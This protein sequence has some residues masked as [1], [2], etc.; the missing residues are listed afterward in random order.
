[1][2]TMRH[3]AGARVAAIGIAAS[4]ALLLVGCGAANEGGPSSGGGGSA[5][6]MVS[7]TISG[8]GAST[9]QAA[10]QAWVAGFTAIN[11]DAVINYDPTGSGAGRTQFMVG[12]VDWA[13]SDAYLEGDELG[14]ANQRCGSG[15]IVEGPVYISPIAVVYNLPGVPN[16]QLSPAT[17]AKIFDR[18][19]TKW[20]DPAVAADN[21]R[22][23]LPAMPI[24][25]VNRSD[26]S[27]TTQNFTDYLKGA[28]GVDWPYD[29]ADTWPVAGEEAAQGTSGVVGAVKVGSGTIGYVDESQAAGLG[30]AKLKVGD[31]Y[32]APSA[33]GAAKLLEASQRVTDGGPDVFA[34]TLARDTTASGMYP[35]TLVSYA[36]ACARYPDPAKANLV[37]TYL[38]YVV[39][40]DGQAAAQKA[41]GSAPL[42]DALRA[43]ITPA[44]QSIS[45]GR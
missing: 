36:I 33:E 3:H 15:G 42:S 4:G 41:A 11:P 25:P 28:A 2:K 8:A 21:P 45:A 10:T 34:F 5:V 6:A 19:I 1:M 44:V 14:K 22:A 16:L 31:A 17:A 43:Q 23:A 9:Q 40:A 18:K 12:G 30:V 29:V 7:G 24:A 32:V 26:K 13:G 39:S 35:A 38:S 20:N 27:G 37:K